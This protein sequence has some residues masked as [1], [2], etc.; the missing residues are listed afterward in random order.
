MSG[1]RNKADKKKS[2]LEKKKSLAEEQYN[3]LISAF[4]NSED[5]E[6]LSSAG[7]NA[8]KLEQYAL[9]QFTPSF[10]FQD[11]PTVRY[12]FSGDYP[13]EQK[14]ITDEIENK[15]KIKN[16]TTSTTKNIIELIKNKKLSPE[17]INTLNALIENFIAFSEKK[18]D[19][20]YQVKN[21]STQ[22]LY[23]RL[24]DCEKT[25]TKN[26]TCNFLI[27]YTDNLLL[28]LEKS[29]EN[30]SDINVKLLKIN[31]SSIEASR[32][33]LLDHIKDVL[34]K[35]GV[36]NPSSE[37]NIDLLS[38]QAVQE[39]LKSFIDADK[40]IRL[41]SQMEKIDSL[42]RQIGAIKYNPGLRDDTTITDNY[43][44][45][46]IKSVNAIKYYT[47]KYKLEHE[48]KDFENE[49][50]LFQKNHDA[51][52]KALNKKIESEKNK[53][54]APNPTPAKP[55]TSGITAAPA[56]E[57]T[58]ASKPKPAVTTV[59]ESTISSAA[60]PK[61]SSPTALMPIEE[62][63]RRQEEISR[64]IDQ[65]SKLHHKGASQSSRL[66]QGEFDKA[67]EEHEIASKIKEI[68]ESKGSLSLSII[69]PI[70]SPQRNENIEAENNAYKQ[71][72]DKIA[73]LI[74]KLIDAADSATITS[75]NIEGTLRSTSATNA[76]T[77]VEAIG[78]IDRLIR[79]IIKE[80]KF[81]EIDLLAAKS[82]KEA[83]KEV[84]KHVKI[85]SQEAIA[86][87]A[88]ESY[89]TEETIPE[90]D[91]KFNKII[92][93]LNENIDILEK[94]NTNNRWD[95][96]L[97]DLKTTRDYLQN[98]H[99]IESKEQFLAVQLPLVISNIK[100]VEPDLEIFTISDE[101]KKLNTI[102]KLLQERQKLISKATTLS[103]I[104]AITKTSNEQ[105][106]RLL[107]M[108]TIE[109]TSPAER[110][111]KAGIAK[112]TIQAKRQTN[113]ADKP[114]EAAKA[115]AG[116][117]EN[118]DYLQNLLNR[119]HHALKSS[120]NA[121]LQIANQQ[122]LAKTA[123]I[124][125]IRITSDDQVT[126][127]YS[128]ISELDDL[129]AEINASAKTAADDAEINS[130]EQIQKK[131][132]S[133]IDLFKELI[134]RNPDKNQQWQPYLTRLSEIKSYL[135]NI[136]NSDTD[137]LHFIQPRLAM[138][139]DIAEEISPTIAITSNVE[140]YARI[141][142]A[143]GII[144]DIRETIQTESD[145]EKIK[146]AGE[147]NKSLLKEQLGITSIPKQDHLTGTDILVAKREVQETAAAC[148]LELESYC[149][150][151]KQYTAATHAELAATESPQPSGINQPHIIK[152]KEI[153]SILRVRSNNIDDKESSLKKKTDGLIQH[154]NTILSSI[155]KVDS[156]N[157]DAAE[158]SSL[159]LN[160]SYQ[161]ESA[162][163]LVNEPA[164]YSVLTDINDND[165]IINI[166]KI[167]KGTYS[168]KQ[169][170]SDKMTSHKDKFKSLI[171]FI[172]PIQSYLN[173]QSNEPNYTI[174]NN[175]LRSI[176]VL[177]TDMDEKSTLTLLNNIQDQIDNA[178][179][180]HGESIRNDAPLNQFMGSIYNKCDDLLQKYYPGFYEANNVLR[181]ISTI[182]SQPDVNV[183][184][185]ATNQPT[186]EHTLKIPAL[187]LSNI[188]S[189]S[190]GL[191]N[192]RPK[193]M[194]NAGLDI[195][196]EAMIFACRASNYDYQA[197]RNGK[198]VLIKINKPGEL[199]PV[200]PEEARIQ[201]LRY[202]RGMLLIL[203]NSASI[204][205]ENKDELIKN[206]LSSY[207]Q[208]ISFN[209]ATAHEFIDALTRQLAASYKISI[210]AA[211]SELSKAKNMSELL[212]KHPDIVTCSSENGKMTIETASLL[213]LSDT[214]YQENFNN[215]S[216]QP[217]FQAAEKN[218]AI[219]G[220]AK[221]AFNSNNERLRQLG[222]P[223][224][225]SARWLPQPSNA[226][227]IE[228]YVVSANN[229][230]VIISSS[231]W[232]R[233]G[234][235]GL[236]GISENKPAEKAALAE[237]Q[238]REVADQL[239]PDAANNLNNLYAPL[240]IDPRQLPVYISYQTLMTPHYIEGLLSTHE[241]N[242]NAKFVDLT[243]RIFDKLGKQTVASGAVF[244]HTNAAINKMTLSP[245]AKNSQK[246]HITARNNKI[247]ATETLLKSI[248]GST[249]TPPEA[250]ARP[251]FF[252]EY[253]Q[254]ALAN[255]ENA[256]NTTHSTKLKEEIHRRAYAF[257]CLKQLLADKPPYNTLHTYQR[258]LMMAA[259]EFHM[260]GSQAVTIAGCKSARDRTAVFAAAVK[261]MQENPE[262]M[263]S[264]ETLNKGIIQSLEQG[265]H[266][267]AMNFHCGVAKID[268]VHRSYFDQLDQTTRQGIQAISQFTKK[269]A[270]KRGPVAE[271]IAE[272][273][274]AQ[275]A[276]SA[277]DM[278]TY[279]GGK[280]KR[281][282]PKP[283]P[284]LP[285]GKAP[286]LS[287]PDKAQIVTHIR[288][289]I[290]RYQNMA[291]YYAVAAQRAANSVT[292]E[293]ELKKIQALCDKMNTQI[294]VYHQS[295][296][297]ETP[298]NDNHLAKIK[299]IQNHLAKALAQ[300]KQQNIAHFSGQSSVIPCNLDNSDADII[301]QA[302][303]NKSTNPA[304]FGGL[305][306]AH[307]IQ[308]TDPF[309]NQ[310]RVNQTVIRT[311]G[312]LGQ[313]SATEVISVQRMQH[314]LFV[315]NFYA[316][317]P[318][319]LKKFDANNHL[320]W[321]VI[322]VENFRAANPEP[323]EP[324]TIKGN[325]PPKL[326]KEIATYCAAKGYAY[327]ITVENM[328][329]FKPT[330]KDIKTLEQRLEKNK[331][332][333][334]GNA[335]VLATRR[336]EVTAFKREIKG[337]PFGGGTTNN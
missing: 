162:M 171:E 134:E 18:S 76:K 85:T 170:I 198:P 121:E 222:V 249:L 101:I 248:T 38:Q 10:H 49:N 187:G 164:M 150:S 12:A 89:T 167:I 272:P 233:L 285:P 94:C 81:R 157:D 88:E 102:E 234:T 335:E 128:A 14:K 271:S 329:D 267:R 90:L 183:P 73:P 160:L 304:Q 190:P 9:L 3:K 291:R 43:N 140:E 126:P 281:S 60:P 148:Y 144:H 255:K 67:R 68:I 181:S 312:F 141:Q 260:M 262:A 256:D 239:L 138:L 104:E 52:L 278:V 299:D 303:G 199:N 41:M 72:V 308:I 327:R 297:S 118:L 79:E 93:E 220:W 197:E 275:M 40:L 95:E 17:T 86:K 251:A 323:N 112:A 204:S 21:K 200:H 42:K 315:S 75:R 161:I 108:R 217:W 306:V 244:S 5:K 286:V 54:I 258:N 333:I 196:I 36:I 237:R 180:S 280:L 30:Q 165:E 120:T 273:V 184:P 212:E 176:V 45:Q 240:N 316:A 25:Q 224:S 182:L 241:N 320:Q 159:L 77:H 235:I 15:L 8:A 153:E 290:E 264:W 152:L 310:A 28:S 336:E 284:K 294:A 179:H 130:I 302:L 74:D 289:D 192:D 80:S 56:A 279:V 61:K 305:T 70:K 185:A 91:R 321:A 151:L 64:M 137:K 252:A 227:K 59:T 155:D 6:L 139:Q 87:A 23:L 146:S 253:I 168:A 246:A 107:K 24:D 261:T 247:A 292:G 283:P 169:I 282:K 22:E 55:P 232:C 71:Y 242:N 332:I 322:E 295:L 115:A 119:K 136:K 225:S 122:V 318:K 98:N 276:R 226:Q 29:L 163:R 65:L 48:Y 26:D 50:N 166:L 236:S 92:V 51:A 33:A 82:K 110:M 259:L 301:S 99:P 277:N 129:L 207:N 31:L 216:S 123:S 4:I 106:N 34:V 229:P 105:I 113:D 186:L 254:R 178:R 66:D 203:N 69:N 205:I 109:A 158:K 195:N 210:D 228:T 287:D 213:Q 2:Q 177:H 142:R 143:L 20:E 293:A 173:A 27:I 337:P 270:G 111:L 172:A 188:S 47:A 309:N 191:W 32:A 219:P 201:A 319:T 7:I 83:Q 326:V 147:A 243:S 63:E 313:Q 325:M 132:V 288:S 238:I 127:A 266:F 39:N 221:A 62:I 334:Y 328:R 223:A 245:T 57:A 317:D 35:K 13:I 58:A 269:Y 174:A 117:C 16:K 324:I 78:K 214:F 100:V 314:G 149:Q 194:V 311:K 230:D 231:Q 46:Y 331:A 175:L 307:D 11:S 296:S 263:Y 124:P 37:I 125:G 274:T 265:H 206:M 298:R 209:A 268:K 114:K 145:H 135:T 156:L 116:I 53:R 131:I 44:N 330:D 1:N 257:A 84:R 300:Q 208:I 97:I 19:Y 202:M 154:L 250:F 103:E 189:I 211:S 96:V 133:H 218:F 215:L 193:L